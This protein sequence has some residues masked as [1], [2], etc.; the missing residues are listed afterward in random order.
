MPAIYRNIY[1]NLYIVIYYYYS[2]DF[3]CQRRNIPKFLHSI[4]FKSSINSRRCGTWSEAEFFWFIVTSHIGSSSEATTKR[5]SKLIRVK[6]IVRAEIVHNHRIFW[7]CYH[8]RRMLQRLG[9]IRRYRPPELMPKKRFIWPVA[10]AAI[11]HWFLLD[12]PQVCNAC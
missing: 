6:I 8:V 12:L 4:L 1:F 5:Y 11:R 2:I 3:S 7:N 9:N 10:L